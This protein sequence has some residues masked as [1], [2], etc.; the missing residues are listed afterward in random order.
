MYY[1]LGNYEYQTATVYLTKGYLEYGQGDL[2][3][4]GKVSKNIVL[5]KLLEIRTVVIPNAVQQFDSI[6]YLQIVLNLKNLATSV[7]IKTI[8]G[9]SG[10][11]IGYMFK[12]TDGPVSEAILNPSDRTPVENL[13]IRETEFI[14]GARAFDL[15]LIAEPAEYDVFPYIHVIQTGLPDALTASLYKTASGYHPNYLNIPFRQNQGR[16]T[17][18]SGP[19]SALTGIDQEFTIQKN[20][21]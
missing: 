6:A 7:R 14:G 21:K 20:S 16:L 4:D 11:L 13:I 17:C 8:Q 12:K 15:G 19:G 9:P 10:N 18:F 1:Y 2:G 3:D 5:E